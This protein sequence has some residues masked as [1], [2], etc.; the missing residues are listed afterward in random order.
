MNGQNLLIGLSHID[1]KFIEESENDT[2]VSEIGT[3]KR[4]TQGRKVLRKPL[5]IAAIVALLLFLMG[6]AAVILLH[7]DDLRIGAESYIAHMQYQEDGSKIPATE[8]MKNSIGIVGAEN[9]KNYQAMMEWME[10]LDSLDPSQRNTEEMNVTRKAICD[11]YGLKDTD[12]SEILQSYDEEL[13]HELTGI[14][15]ILSEN[16]QLTAEFGGA[17]L[18]ESGAFNAG[19]DVFMEDYNFMMDYQYHNKE[20]FSNNYFIIEDADSVQQW[21]YTRKDG[22]EVLIVSEKGDNTQILCDREDAFIC[23]TVKN[24]G[25]NWDNPS[26]VMTKQD[27]E[28]IAESLDFMIAPKPIEDMDSAIERITL[29]REAYENQDTSVQDAQRLKE[30]EENE[31]HG[32]YAELISCMRNHEDYFTSRKNAG[33][34]NFWETMEYTLRDVTGDGEEELL[35]GKNGSIYAIWTI[36]DGVTEHL[37]G[38]YPEGYLCEGNVFEH[39]SFLDGQHFHFYRQLTN[40]GHS[41]KILDVYYERATENW[42]LDQSNDGSGREEISE[43]EAM[44][45]IAGFSRVELDMKPVKEFPLN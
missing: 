32:S 26:D 20:Y 37:E 12:K 31:L 42:I 33:Y 34:E 44:K 24:V 2:I 38:G 40:D 9:S 10:Y 11:K 18:V 25:P 4:A 22:T 29:S 16:A 27:I 8:K 43:D 39:Y 6:C 23:V 17:I 13:F 1:R 41:T 21:N 28:Q 3:H 15:G 36:W 45:I 14:S 7:L 30:Y 5:L 19:Y 35:L